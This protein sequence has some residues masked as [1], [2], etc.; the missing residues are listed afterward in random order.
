MACTS[1][2]L[3]TPHE[4]CAAGHYCPAGSSSRQQEPCEAGTYN[5]FHNATNQADCVQCR[6]GFACPEGTGGLQQP[7]EACAPGHFCIA[8]TTFRTE[9]PCVAGSYSNRT[10]NQ[11]Q[12]DCTACPKGYYCLEGATAPSGECPQGHYCPP[13]TTAA[14]EY[15]CPSGTYYDSTGNIREEDCLVCPAGHY[16]GEGS[17]TPTACSA[18]TFSSAE[19]NVGVEQC[20]TCTAGYECPTDGM[21]APT[22]CRVGFYSAAGAEDCSV[23][24]LLLCGA[25]C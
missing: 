19:G 23:S 14:T 24:V 17:A 3:V 18:G 8:G 22:N 5:D 16:C 10:D 15:P 1:L 9:R 21:T 20:T 4:T 12:A 13:S 11:E 2:A 6:F 7:P 25:L